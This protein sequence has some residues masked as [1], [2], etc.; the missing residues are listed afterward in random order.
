M[1]WSLA[2]GDNET[3]ARIGWALWLAWWLGGTWREGREWMEQ[4]LAHPLT[5]AVRVR[6]NLAAASMAYAEGAID[7]AREHWREA[8]E[9]ATA[10]HD[11]DAL[12]YAVGGIALV[13]MATGHDVRAAEQLLRTVEL[14]EQHDQD[15]LWS[16]A[17]VWLGTVRLLQGAS[18]EAVGLFE[19]GLSSA[20]ARGDRLVIY[21][22][23]YNLT[24]VALAR[25]ETRTARA[26]VLES[27]E[28]SRVTA[29]ARTW[30][31]AS[32]RLPRSRHGKAAICEQQPC[33][34]RPMVCVWP[35][36]HGRTSITWP[37]RRIGNAP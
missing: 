31:T 5:P 25:D 18:G 37:L 3:A 30:P 33:S 35:S 2:S 10:A 36:A 7:D 15:W 20:R 28:L 29:T 27:V 24:Q 16:L 4:A 19:E 1:T 26:W 32:T 6:A 9:G 22:A 11:A 21:V 23:L 13:S 17:K 12:G 8:V 14:A 34:A